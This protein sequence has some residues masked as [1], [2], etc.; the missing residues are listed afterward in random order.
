[1]LSVYFGIRGFW[2]ASE[3]ISIYPNC[4]K[5]SVSSE[6]NVQEACSL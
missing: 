1:M 6:W 4:H 5:I 3:A 2:Q